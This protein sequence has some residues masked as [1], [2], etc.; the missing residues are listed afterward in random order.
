MCSGGEVAWPP[1]AEALIDVVPDAVAL[2]VASNVTELLPV[3]TTMVAGRLE[4]LV[5]SGVEIVSS[6]A[7]EVVALRVTVHST[8]FPA[9][10]VSGLIA[11]T[12]GTGCSRISSGV[13]WST[14][15]DYLRKVMLHVPP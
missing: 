15:A 4:N 7:S 6:S 10:T 9:N 8:T 3:S 11:N 2:T 13:D 14:G 1:F 12:T 5:G